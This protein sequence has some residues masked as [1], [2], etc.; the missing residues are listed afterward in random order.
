[1]PPR[2]AIWTSSVDMQGDEQLRDRFL[3]ILIDETQTSAI[4]EFMKE[5][6]K[7]PQNG[8]DKE[9]ENAV[10]RGLFSDL[11]SKTF[12]VEI[13]FADEFE[14]LT[15]EGTR[16][17]GIF[18]DMIKGFAALRYAKRETNEQGHLLATYQ[19]FYDAKDLY[20]GLMGHSDMKFSTSE[21]EVL[22][23]LITEPGR[24]ANIKQLSKKT[25]K[26]ETRIREILNGRS[27]DEQ[28]RHGL[29]AKCPALTVDYET[30]TSRIR[31]DESISRKRNVYTLDSG[32][33]L[34]DGKIDL[35]PVICGTDLAAH[36][37]ESEDKDGFKAWDSRPVASTQ[38]TFA[39]ATA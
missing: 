1:M 14:F 34:L 24:T 15:T 6:D 36:K 39:S 10:C 30:A 2:L 31:E 29:L 13:P 38:N 28:K 3:F 26:S 7:V 21:Q 35:I 12:H 16:G 22:T 5:K 20:E 19:D 27:N 8:D 11:A 23:A 17:Y 4:I 18:S 25:G 37:P 9:F 33:K 32:F